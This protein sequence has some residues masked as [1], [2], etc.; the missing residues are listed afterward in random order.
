[1]SILAAAA[2]TGLLALMTLVLY[3][4]SG[5]IVVLTA[6][7]IGAAGAGVGGLVTRGRPWPGVWLAVAAG[8]VI[9]FVA[10]GAAVFAVLAAMYAG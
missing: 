10:G 6:L 7:A 9:G 4:S 3:V 1:V 5:Q 2:L 8:A